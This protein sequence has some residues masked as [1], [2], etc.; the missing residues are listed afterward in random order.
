MFLD[1]HAFAMS[2]W[3]ALFFIQT[4]LISVRRVRLHRN[5]G[6]LGMASAALVPNAR[7]F[8]NNHGHRNA[9]SL[10]TRGTLPVVITVLALELTQMIMCS[11]FAA[12]GY[13]LIHHA[14]YHKRFM[15]LA[16]FCM[17]PN[18]IVRIIRMQSFLVPLAIWSLLIAIAVLIDLPMQGRLHPVFGNWAFLQVA[19]LW[20]ALGIGL[21][22][23][24]QNLVRS[25]VS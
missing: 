16:T 23:T 11:G 12:T 6:I 18:A 7:R 20:V 4:M 22:T 13:F 25:Y 1:V 21:S 17:V 24:W 3:I 14:G 9:K 19:L 5:L 8:S 2:L 10:R 15:L